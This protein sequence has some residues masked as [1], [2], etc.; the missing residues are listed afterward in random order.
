MFAKL[1]ASLA[2]GLWQYLLIALAV[3]TAGLG[4]AYIL[5]GAQL[6]D[7]R[8]DL[9][10]LEADLELARRTIASQIAALKEC[11]DKTLA[12]KTESDKKAAA[13]DVALAAAR[14]DAARYQQAN[15]RLS[16]LTVAPTPSGAGCSQ[17]LGAIRRELRK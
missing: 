3:A 7:A 5:R 15:Q 16:A 12:L 4:L 11:S 17:A 9:T 14:K 8:A 6:T 2:G 1:L 10:V 13:T